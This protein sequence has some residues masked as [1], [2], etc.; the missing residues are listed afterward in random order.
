MFDERSKRKMER[1]LRQRLRQGLPGRLGIELVAL[2]SGLL[3][4]RMAVGEDHMA[5]NGYL[6]AGSV[7]ALADTACGFGC[8]AHLPEGAVN[9]ATA[10][11]KSNFLRTAATGSVIW[12]AAQLQHS[13]RRTQV[14]DA[15]VRDERERELALF[16]CTQILLYVD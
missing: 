14:W 9:Y 10:E 4:V 8:L 1:E 16:R 6:H 15:I 13:G 3:T 12:T 5:A 11:L 2:D 7:V